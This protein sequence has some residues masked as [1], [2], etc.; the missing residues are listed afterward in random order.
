MAVIAEVVA[1][2]WAIVRIVGIVLLFGLFLCVV[3][4]LA[5]REPQGPSS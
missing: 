4:A 5:I 3:A 1:V 2:L